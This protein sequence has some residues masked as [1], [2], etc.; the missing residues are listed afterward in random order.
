MSDKCHKC[1][2]HPQSKAKTNGN[3]CV[4]CLAETV[5]TLKRESDD[6]LASLAAARERAE[7]AEATVIRLASIMV[8]KWYNRS[9]TDED[10]AYVIRL[11]EDK[12]TKA[13]SLQPAIARCPK[14]LW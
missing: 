10:R 7:R 2:K 9:I 4:D 8:N 3:L 11:V 6:A 1:C 12:K 13:A 5:N 14:R